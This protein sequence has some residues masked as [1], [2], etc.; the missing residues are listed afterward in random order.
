MTVLLVTDYVWGII[1]TPPPIH[2]SWCVLGKLYQRGEIRTWV[3][4]EW[5]RF[6]LRRKGERHSINGQQSLQTQA[7]CSGEKRKAVSCHLGE[8]NPCFFS[9]IKYTLFYL[10]IKLSSSS[11]KEE[12]SSE[13]KS[14]SD[15]FSCI[16]HSSLLSLRVVCWGMNLAK[17]VCPAPFRF[18]L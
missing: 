16:C 9:L 2:G 4:H 1:L 15:V 12:I 11:M 8:G 3:F 5:V 13:G 7:W 18:S 17:H 6:S 10:L 14:P